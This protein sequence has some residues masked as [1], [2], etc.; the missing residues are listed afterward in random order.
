M[1]VPAAFAIPKWKAL[2]APPEQGDIFGIEGVTLLL[3]AVLLVIFGY[4]LAAATLQPLLNFSFIPI[5][6]LA[7]R[8]GMRG[9]VAG[10]VVAFLAATAMHV[11]LSMP[12]HAM[13]EYQTFLIASA[14][15]SLL[16]GAMTLE[17]WDLQSALA[18]RAFVDDLTGLPNRD[19]LEQWI[20]SHRETAIVLV[21]LDIDEMRL[22]NEGI[23]RVAADRTLQDI[24]FRLR[25]G[26]PTSYLVARVS[27]DE[28]AIAVVDDRSPHAMMQ[29]VRA[30][31]DVPF[32]VDDS[33]VFVSVSLGAVRVVRAGSAD[34][35]LRKA[36]VALY[37]AKSSPSRTAVYSADLPGREAPSLVGELHRAVENGELTPFFQPIFEFDPARE[38]W[39]VVGA[40]ALLRWVHPERGVVTPAEFLDLLERLTISERVGWMVVEK[41]LRQA[42]EWRSAVPAFRVWVN[43][44]ARQALD[45]SCAR[46]M[47]RILSETNAP[48]DSLVVEISERIVAS[49]ER[50]VADLVTELKRLGIGTA[51]DDFGT[52]GSSLGRVRDVPAEVLK[53]DRS[54][55]T[56]SEV[57]PKAK[58]VSS[59]IVRLAGELG[60]TVVAEGVEN[61]AQ[62][63]VMHETGCQLMQGYALGHPLPAKLFEQTFLGAVV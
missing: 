19:R 25:T 45:G 3:L 50:D 7:I 8:Y 28:F 44:F 18:R 29:E 41:S 36:D 20:E 10:L 53:I 33:R 27:A 57:D 1:I 30:L 2:A 54:F 6:W 46:H 17:R 49:D 38:R 63:Q 34:E 55:V 11:A 32:A 58:A 56:R 9:A 52:G 60:M 59:T 31:F 24:S 4:V 48:P 40:E 26:L 21:M 12:P 23:G 43:L 5:A 13:V 15:T 14:L 42:L 39:Q 47:L 22:L 62:L 37:R 35:M 16:L 51:I 61:A